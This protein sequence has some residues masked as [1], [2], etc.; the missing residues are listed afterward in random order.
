MLDRVRDFTSRPCCRATTSS[1]RTVPTTAAASTP[2]AARS[3]TTTSIPAGRVDGPMYKLLARKEKAHEM[4]VNCVQWSPMLLIWY[5][6]SGK[7]VRIC[8]ISKLV[9]NF[10]VWI[11]DASDFAS[12]SSR[13]HASFCKL[14]TAGNNLHHFDGALVSNLPVLETKMLNLG[15]IPTAITLPY[16]RANDSHKALAY[17]WTVGILQQ[18][19]LYHSMLL[20]TE[21]QPV[22]TLTHGVVLLICHR[23]LSSIGKWTKY[24]FWRE[25]EVDE[26]K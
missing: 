26:I 16:S 11:V 8:L 7:A 19:G 25:K 12:I 15:P 5:N 13:C 20:E 10:L 9:D 24:C 22:G 2:S 3:S 6:R 23:K 14:K 4:D 17:G 18:C 21:W 1:A